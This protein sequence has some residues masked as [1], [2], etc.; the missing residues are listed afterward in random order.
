MFEHLDID[1]GPSTRSTRAGTVEQ[2]GPGDNQSLCSRDSSP[3]LH[4]DEF[5]TQ[6]SGTFGSSRK[7][8]L[9]IYLRRAYHIVVLGAGLCFYRCH[10]MMH[11]PDL[12]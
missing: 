11:E 2:D 7:S 5:A 3:H 10:Q 12:P 1:R 6:V 8:V 4:Q 9:L